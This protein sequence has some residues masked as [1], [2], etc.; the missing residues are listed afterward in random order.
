MLLS[1]RKKSTCYD[2]SSLEEPTVWLPSK[3]IRVRTMHLTQVI[4]GHQK[5]VLGQLNRV[6][7]LKGRGK[8][9]VKFCMQGAFLSVISLVTLL[10]LLFQNNI[11]LQDH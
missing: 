1:F 10:R 9:S 2:P 4:R 7:P 8:K 6:W 11:N 5:N 3:A